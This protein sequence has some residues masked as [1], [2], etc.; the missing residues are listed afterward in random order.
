[1]PAVHGDGNPS[2]PPGRNNPAAAAVCESAFYPRRCSPWDDAAPFEQR[3][4][5]CWCYCCCSG[6]ALSS[7]SCQQQLLCGCNSLVAFFITR[8]CEQL[9]EGNQKISAPSKLSPYGFSDILNRFPILYVTVL[10]LNVAGHIINVIKRGSAN[11]R[12]MERKNFTPQDF[13]IVN[14]TKKQSH[15]VNSF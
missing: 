10:L 12:C 6:S 1:M 5:C 7:P 15:Y 3:D 2:P 13:L 9:I 11:C 4:S 8:I 14:V